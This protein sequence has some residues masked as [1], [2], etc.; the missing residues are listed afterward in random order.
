[1]KSGYH[2]QIIL[3]VIECMER[4][5][6]MLREQIAKVLKTDEKK[7]TRT[8]REMFKTVVAESESMIQKALLNIITAV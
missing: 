5:V 6:N 4:D 7:M 3:M 1:M 2:V 8:W